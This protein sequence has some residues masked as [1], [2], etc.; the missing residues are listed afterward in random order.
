MPD[1]APELF[2]EEKVE[3]AAGALTLVCFGFLAS[4]LPRICPLATVISPG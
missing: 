3:A 2:P 1:G 4:R